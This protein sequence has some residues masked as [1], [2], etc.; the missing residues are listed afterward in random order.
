M[1]E[2][3]NISSRLPCPI[4]V[5]QLGFLPHF[6]TRILLTPLYIYLCISFSVL[7][8]CSRHHTYRNMNQ[9][10]SHTC[11]C[12]DIHRAFYIH[13]HLHNKEIKKISQLLT[14]IFFTTIFMSVVSVVSA[15]LREFM[16]PLEQILSEAIHSINI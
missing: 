15:N 4:I 3:P 8:V 11:S 10:G 16:L 13:P 14:T 5:N 9:E 6:M 12:R 7:S 2:C 1:L